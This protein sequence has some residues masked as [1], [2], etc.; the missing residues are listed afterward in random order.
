M[1]ESHTKTY[2]LTRPLASLQILPR[3]FPRHNLATP[4]L[5]SERRAYLLHFASGVEKPTSP[6][7]AR[8]SFCIELDLSLI[9][10]SG[11]RPLRRGQLARPSPPASQ[12]L[13]HLRKPPQ[14][15]PM[16]SQREPDD[17]RVNCSASQATWLAHSRSQVQG[18]IHP[19][20][21]HLTERILFGNKRD[22]S[23]AFSITPSPNTVTSY[24]LQC[25]QLLCLQEIAKQG[26]V[27][28]VFDSNY[29][30]H[31]S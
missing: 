21:A 20:V 14:A 15:R 11:K 8:I 13:L 5:P 26:A 16:W 29:R 2:V 22:R 6:P 1:F 3:N 27:H 4:L 19:D 10:W 9:G 25:D 7:A 12:W 31:N 28:V 18:L 24:R 17:R 23:C 30:N